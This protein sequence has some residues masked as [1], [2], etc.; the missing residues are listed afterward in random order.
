MSFKT[1]E[2][3]SV[4]APEIVLLYKSNSPYE[5]DPD[6]ENTVAALSNKQRN[7]L[8]AALEKLFSQHIWIERLTIF[9]GT[10]TPDVAQRRLVVKAIF[11]CATPYSDDE[12]NLPVE[13]VDAAIPFYETVMGF[14]LISRSDSP[15]KSAILARDDVKVGL[16]ENGGDPTQEG[17]FFVVDNVETAFAELQLNGLQKKEAEYRIDKHSDKSWKVFFVVAPDG[18][19]YCL[20]EQVPSA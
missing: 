16:A 7:W 13:N 12:M 17:C 8:K 10:L 9:S 20:G 6:F 18:L 19:C 3:R 15:H 4:L 5:Y 11:K 2:G 14:R 1:A